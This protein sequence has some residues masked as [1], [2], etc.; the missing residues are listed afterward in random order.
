MSEHLVLVSS[1]QLSRS[2]ILFSSGVCGIV[3]RVNAPSLG[4]QNVQTREE[5]LLGFIESNQKEMRTNYVRCVLDSSD[6]RIIDFAV[7]FERHQEAET[8]RDICESC[9]AVFTLTICG[10]NR[11]NEISAQYFLGVVM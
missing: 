4:Q 8:R 1:L 5:I 7:T 2:A 9:K 6:G 3:V 10:F 11:A